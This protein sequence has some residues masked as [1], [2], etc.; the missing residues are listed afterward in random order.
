VFGFD[1]EQ[2]GSPVT[3]AGSSL[4]LFAIGAV[5]PL[6]PWFFTEGTPAI[7]ASVIATA[8]ASVVVGAWVSRSA[9]RPIVHGAL[10]Q[11]AIVVVVAAVTYAIGKMFG[12]TIS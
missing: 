12:T 3:A 7:V 9:Q 8:L 5:I 1:T 6:M 2:L 10:R 4:G 11:L